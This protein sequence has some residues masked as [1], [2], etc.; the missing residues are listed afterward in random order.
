M[1]RYN[2]D[3]GVLLLIHAFVNAKIITKCVMN[4][5]SHLDFA[6]NVKSIRH[7]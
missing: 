7:L 3:L 6:Y 5:R 1:I 2:T 4:T